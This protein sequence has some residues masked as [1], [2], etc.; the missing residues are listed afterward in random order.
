MA[1]ISHQYENMRY[2]NHTLLA[3]KKSPSLTTDTKHITM[4]VCMFVTPSPLILRDKMWDTIIVHM[5]YPSMTQVWDRSL[6]GNAGSHPA[7]RKD[8]RLL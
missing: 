6:A 8:V 4:Y 3:D 5:T 1:A 7:R 2:A